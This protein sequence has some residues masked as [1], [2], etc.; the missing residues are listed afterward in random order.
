MNDG[1][2]LGHGTHDESVRFV[3]QIT[4]VVKDLIAPNPLIY[5]A[6]F[7]LTIVIGNVALAWC[8]AAPLWSPVFWMT[9]FVAGFAFYR[10]TVFSHELT[11]FRPGTFKRFR[12]VWNALCG[13][14]FMLP[15]FL[16]DDHKAHHTNHK[17][18]TSVD[19]EYL[20]L[21]HGSWLGIVQFM[22][23]IFLVPVMGLV[24]FVFLA[25]LAWL[26][27]SW[28][29]LVWSQSS[30]A[31]AMNMLHRR[32]LPNEQE[33]RTWLL[34]EVICFVYAITI[35]MLMAFGV[36]PWTLL[37]Y[38][39]F[40]FLLVALL[41]YTR[42]LGAH[43][44]L[45]DGEPMSYVE[46]LLDSNTFPGNPLL[47]E[48]WAPLGMRYHA[49]HHLVPSLPYHNMGRAHRRLMRELPDDSPYRRTVRKNLGEALGELARH[50]WQSTHERVQTA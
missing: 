41:N 50:S 4:E 11:H 24:R 43:R 17:Y 7:L 29:A 20:P 33:A 3:R 23:K 49:L 21:G 9:Y 8:M 47:T 10:A 18:G 30:A 46:Q 42:T 44:Y 40:T 22:S 15:T 38:Y 35:F 31:L 39:Y 14:P 36:L 5:W 6:D 26:F 12:F 13:V 48:L 2:V 45:H 19:A 37:V 28:R 1:M 16:Y 25:P 34:Q 32:P 27:P